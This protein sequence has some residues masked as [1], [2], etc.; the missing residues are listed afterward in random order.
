MTSKN[1]STKDDA[2]QNKKT[3]SARCVAAYER[4]ITG[5][6][7]MQRRAVLH[8]P[9]G[10]RDHKLSE[11][12]RKEARKVVQRRTQEQFITASF[13]V[14]CIGCDKQFRAKSKYQRKCSACKRR[15]DPRTSKVID[16]CVSSER[17]KRN[18][19]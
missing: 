11:E 18:N 2:A 12:E 8:A 14:Q 16:L 19:K 13:D 5:G 10:K 15:N 6:I 7:A 4:E 3:K 9:I 17:R 1:A